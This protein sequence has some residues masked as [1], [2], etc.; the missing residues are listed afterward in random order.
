MKRN[1][2]TFS[3]AF[4]LMIVLAVPASAASQETKTS[5]WSQK[6]L[7]E[8][9]LE[10]DI[11]SIFDGKDLNAFITVEDFQK[12]IRLFIDEEYDGTPTQVQERPLYMSLPGC[13]QVRRGSILM[14]LRQLRC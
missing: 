11:N 2:F 7:D 8:L 12:A 10:H 13:G 5:H 3:I 14:I 9:A 6:F 1:L 4:L